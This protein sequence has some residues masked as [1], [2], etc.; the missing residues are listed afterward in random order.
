MRDERMEEL[1][2]KDLSKSEFESLKDVYISSKI[3]SM[4]EDDLREFVKEK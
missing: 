4:T 1:S 2:Y 3:Q